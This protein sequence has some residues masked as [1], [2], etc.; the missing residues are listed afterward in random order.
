ME[1]FYEKNK[2][3]LEKNGITILKN[4]VDDHEI[5]QARNIMEK[6]SYLM[7]NTRDT[8]TALHLASFHRYPEF[9]KLH[10]LL[11]CNN[12]V[13]EFLD[14]VLDGKKVRSIGNDD[15]MINRAQHW[16][17]DILRGKYSVYLDQGN[18]CGKDDCH[19]YRIL[20]YLQDSSSLKIIR[21]SHLIPISLENDKHALPKDTDEIIIIPVKKGDIAI[22]DIRTTHRGSSESV[23]NTPEAEINKSMLIAT[24]LGSTESKLTDDMEKG[25]FNRL[26]D[27]MAKYL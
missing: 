15:I 11:S 9:E 6:Y 21:G 5:E 3:E 7:K 26:M 10:S 16:H 23:F 27:W 8:K 1:N 4:V 2:Q 14:F 13:L 17:K 24:V 22:M 19:V 25:N 12:I 18:I 20:L